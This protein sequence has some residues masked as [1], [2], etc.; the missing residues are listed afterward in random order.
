MWPVTDYGILG[1]RGGEEELKLEIFQIF[2]A[3]LKKWHNHA[4]KFGQNTWNS[5]DMDYFGKFPILYQLKNSKK[6]WS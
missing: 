4:A 2:S 5:L 3:V 1:G 6:K